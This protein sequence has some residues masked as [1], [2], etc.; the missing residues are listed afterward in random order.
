[1]GEQVMRRKGIGI[2]FIVF[3]IRINHLQPSTVAGSSPNPPFAV[4]DKFRVRRTSMLNDVSGLG[5]ADAM[6]GNVVQIPL[7]PRV[8]S[9][10]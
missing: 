5:S 7:V 10:D 4:A 2:H 3:G 6:P 1:M 9:H 8:G